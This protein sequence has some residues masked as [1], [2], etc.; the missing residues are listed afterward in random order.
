[1]FASVYAIFYLNDG[2]L[3]VDCQSMRVNA[4]AR[5]QCR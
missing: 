3:T 1:M 4:L 5:Q 2:V